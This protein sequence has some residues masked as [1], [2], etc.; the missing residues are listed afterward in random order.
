MR[1][2]GRVFTSEESCGVASVQWP[3]ESSTEELVSRRRDRVLFSLVV[4]Y[5]I[6]TVALATIRMFY[7]KYVAVIFRGHKGGYGQRAAHKSKAAD[8]CCRAL[9]FHVFLRLQSF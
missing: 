2:G 6:G 9:I 5:G 8:D 3:T 4:G 7:L 1:D